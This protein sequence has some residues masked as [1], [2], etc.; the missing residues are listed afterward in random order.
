M[1]NERQGWASRVFGCLLEGGFRELR[2]RFWIW[3]RLAKDYVFLDLFAVITLY[4]I[5]CLIS[6]CKEISRLP[7]SGIQ[8]Y[9]FIGLVLT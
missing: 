5:I 1:K 8:G 2:K 4:Y 3:D 6:K 7:P 9:G